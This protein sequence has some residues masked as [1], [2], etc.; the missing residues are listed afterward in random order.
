MRFPRLLSLSLICSLIARIS[1]LML[2][3]SNSAPMVNPPNVI[4]L[5]AR[6]PRGLHFGPGKTAGL[7]ATV[8]RRDDS[9]GV[10]IKLRSRCHLRLGH[11]WCLFGSGLTHSSI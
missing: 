3:Q 8:P 4:C 11:G 10:G 5:G 9:P 2:A 6:L 1:V 7:K